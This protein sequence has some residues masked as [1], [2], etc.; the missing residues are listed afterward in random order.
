MT[1]IWLIIGVVFTMA[2]D[3]FLKKSHME[4][5]WYLGLG[6]LLYA[7]G[8]IPVAILFKKMQFGSVFI[9]WEAITVVLALLVAWWYFKEPIT[10]Y[11][12]LALLFALGAIYL[13]YK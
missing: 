2:G 10:T 11:K 4:N 12:G 8:V 9:A 3:V 5:Y 7:M 6:L 1:I 13:S